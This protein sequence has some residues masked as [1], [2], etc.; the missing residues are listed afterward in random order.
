MRAR[1]LLV[2]APVLAAA[3]AAQGEALRDALVLGRTHDDALFEAFNRGYT[4]SPSGTIERA[5]IVTEFRRAVLI[6]RDRAQ[7]GNF[8]F[9]ADDV[10]KALAPDRGLVT[11]VVQVR[12]HPL[13]TF[14]REPAYDLYVSTGPRSPPIGAK[15]VKRDPVYP[16]GGAPGSAVVAV[17]LE[18]SFPRA[19]IE[20][21]AAPV[22]IVTD[23]KAEILWQ[24]RIDLSRYR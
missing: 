4:L 2:I 7:Q 18:A 13:N 9:G 21:A 12:L 11:F 5:E 16:P 14:A 10:A 24:A 17:R 1:L 8:G 15:V 23:E 20:R 3:F 6:V 19:E 22:L